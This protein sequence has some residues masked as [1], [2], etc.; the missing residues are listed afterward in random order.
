MQVKTGLFYKLIAFILYLSIVQAQAQSNLSYNAYPFRH[1]TINNG[2]SHTDAN[3]VVEDKKNFIWIGTYSGLDRYDGYRVKSF[4][5]EINFNKSYLNRIADISIDSKNKLWIATNLGIQFFDP[6]LEKFTAVKI[7]NETQKD[8]EHEIRKILCIR[9]TYILTT[10]KNFKISLYL[11]RAN[12]NL[13]RLP[14][15]I[16]ALC[17][18]FKMDNKE[19]VWIN[20]NT[21]I[22]VL[23]AKNELSK[24][25]LPTL[26]QKIYCS[27]IDKQQHLLIG[28]N[29][30]IIYFPEKIETNNQ[31]LKSYSQPG[32]TIPLESDIGMVTDIIQSQNEYWVSTLKGLFLIKNNGFKFT[33]TNM[34]SEDNGNT[35]SSSYINCL[36]INRS[37]N[38]FVATYGGGVNILDLCNNPFYSNLKST[39]N[40]KSSSEKIV[41]ALAEDGNKIW[42]GFNSMGISYMDKNTGNI[43]LFPKKI[44]NEQGSINVRALKIDQQNNL[45]V[46][47]TNGIAI[48]NASRTNVYVGN[49]DQNLPKTEISSIAF[50]LYNQAWVGTWYDGLCRIRKTPKGEYQT[51]YFKKLFPKNTAFTSSRILNVYADNKFPD[52][53][54]STEEQLVRLVL[55]KNGD[56]VKTYIYKADST[57]K[58]SLSSNFVYCM[59]RQNETLIWVGCIGGGLNKMKLLP[60]GGYEAE[61]FSEKDGLKMKDIESI[62]IDDVG[63]IWLAGNELVKYNPTLKHFS[64]YNNYNDALFSGFKSASCKGKT[65]EIY[66]GGVN[67]FIYFNP[68]KINNNNNKILASPEISDITVNNQILNAD[69]KSSLKKSISFLDKLSLRY[70]ENNLIFHFTSLH[71]ANPLNC[72]FR[73]R[74][75]GFDKDWITTSGNKP[76]AGY[77]NLPYGKYRFELQASNNDEVWSTQTKTLEILITPP[78]YLSIWAKCFYFLLFLLVLIAVYYYLFRWITLKKQLEITEITKSKNEQLHQLQLQFFTNISHD[79]RTPLTLI[80]GAVE[81][82]S[83]ET[84]GRKKN[85]HLSVLQRNSNRMLNMVDELMDFRKAETNGFN[86]AVKEN[87]IQMFLRNIAADFYDLADT[88]NIYFEVN[89]KNHA[90]NVWFD[91]HLVE[92]IV[93]NLLN[94]AFKYT[95]TEGA[96][97]INILDNIDNHTS[98]FA[99]QF[100]LNSGFS[101]QSYFYFLV[102]DNGVGISKASIEKIFNRYYQI[103]DSEHD[104]HLGSGVGLALVKNL[105]LLHKGHLTVYSEFKKGTEFII[106]IPAS[107]EDYLVNEKIVSADT[108]F[109]TSKQ[110]LKPQTEQ[111]NKLKTDSTD[112]ESLGDKTKPKLLIVEDN[113]EIREFLVEILHT[114]YAITE[115]ID[116]VEALAKI[117]K[118]LP[119]I[120]LSDLMMPGMNGT[121]L[122][123]NLKSSPEAASIPFVMLTAKDTLDSKIEG[124]NAGADAYLGKPINLSLLKTTLENLL[125]SQK[126]MKKHI[127]S[128]FLSTTINDTLKLKDKEFYG[129]LIKTIELNIN[130]QELDVNLLC[131]LLS[132][133]RT[134]LYHRVTE[135]S[136]KSLMDLVRSIRLHK[137]IQIMAEE[138]ISIQEILTRIGIQSQSYFT[139]AFKK[140]FG[141]KP[142]E[143]I[144][145]IKNKT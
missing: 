12:N 55:N 143:Y 50:D 92:K 96:I 139:I 117:Q 38:L 48:I 77:A 140:E 105:V 84:V 70:F 109:A 134:K 28:T 60:N 10:D 119:D 127:S 2:L 94:N 115:A 35:L 93:L 128:N 25:I 11:I 86:L 13:F 53:F 145:E 82:M 66:F 54:F 83:D 99:N 15:N 39:I 141:L 80:S 133:S 32:I 81:Q 124:L 73:Y 21:G 113:D 116:G 106:A 61:S 89:I 65:G 26:N 95:K 46:G 4:Y 103:Q 110:Q 91:A 75:A 22:W 101:A 90:K 64:S 112:L 7:N 136:G 68:H 142:S 138:D 135:I 72:K 43:K 19:R 30:S 123:N 56:L 108:E 14:F 49:S 6:E 29:N 58:K 62:Q 126:R 76:Y 67:G 114:D 17:F 40:S 5:N 120:I 98:A 57:K 42:I 33:V 37:E 44:P 132:C 36:L 78:W 23:N 88:K 74:M 63:N 20:S 1:L 18:S 16:N 24:I 71:F 129:L 59:E 31:L 137:A 97:E 111:Q 125:N 27:I 100:S 9:D 121:K 79:F 69:E 8:S 102:R 45:W 3:V 144:R 47:H 122:C 87:D 118:S 131:N 85:K 52:V 104:P 130:N 51:E 41:R 34:N 107:E